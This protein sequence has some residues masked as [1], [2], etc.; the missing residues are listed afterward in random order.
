MNWFAADKRDAEIG[1]G[2]R[3]ELENGNVIKYWWDK[4]QRVWTVQ[5]CDQIG[6]QIGSADYSGTRAG[7]VTYI[8]WRITKV[9]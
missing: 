4:R 8:Q 7:V 5:L 6:N 3:H 2:Y 9:A 1:S